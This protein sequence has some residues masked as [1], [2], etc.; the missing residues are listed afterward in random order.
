MKKIIIFILLF[1]CIFFM[2]IIFVEFF[3]VFVKY[4]LVVDLDL[5]KI[6]YEKDV[7]KFVVIVFLIKIMI[8][9]MVYKEIDNGNFKWN[10][11]VNIFDYFY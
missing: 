11:K 7:N 6:L 5:G 9:Y 2:L 3:N 10:I 1:S 8:V 4:V